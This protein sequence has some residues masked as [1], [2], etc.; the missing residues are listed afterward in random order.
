MANQSYIIPELP[1]NSEDEDVFNFSPYV[2]K[3]DKIL[4][5]NSINSDPL[6][7]GIYGK[8]GEGKTSFL[9]LLATHLSEF[10]D[11]GTSKRI[12]KYHFNPWRY[13]GEDEM[14]LAFFEGLSNMLSIQTNSSLQKAGKFIKKISK[15]FKAIK[16]SSSVGIP[17]FLGTKVTFELNEIL[18]AMGEDLEGKPISPEVLNKVIDDALCESKYKIVIFI[19]DIDRLDK[20]EIYTLFK[21]IKLNANFRNLVYLI[22][23]DPEQVSKAI[24]HRYGTDKLDGKLFIEKIINIPII[25]PR[26][27][28]EDLQLFF[29]KKISDLN[30]LLSLN[31]DNDFKEIAFEFRRFNFNNPRE[32]IRVINSFAISACAIGEEVNLRDLFWIEYLKITNETCYNDI[33][34]YNEET[35]IFTE[36]SGVIDFNDEINTQG[37]PNGFRKH[38]INTYPEIESILNHLFPNNNFQGTGSKI[39]SKT[40]EKE[41]RINSSDHFEKFFSYHTFRKISETNFKIIKNL[42]AEEKEDDL[43]TAI[44][45]LF[46]R[47]AEYKTLYKI[48]NLIEELD[49]DKLLFLSHFLILNINIIPEIGEDMFGRSFRIRIIEKIAIT[50]NDNDISKDYL[51]DLAEEMTLFNLCYFT[52][53]FTVQNVRNELQEVIVRRIKLEKKPFYEEPLNAPNKMIMQIWNNKNSAEF[54]RF[55]KDTLQNDNILLL[56]R[57]FPVYWNNTFFGALT[58]SNYDFMKSIIDVDY[59]YEKLKEYHAELFD[60]HI[61]ISD[62]DFQESTSHTIEENALQFINWHNI[63]KSTSF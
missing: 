43:K 27:E 20:D 2:K 13:S 9:N 61:D 52:R 55:I 3:I 59:I 21:I 14:L 4:Q 16:I 57:N 49:V 62:I 22:A 47:H 8:W 41:L 58:K 33:K 15:Y 24:H 45:N 51:I 26:I 48:E 35:Q 60:K 46:A 28:K 10:K 30:R 17:K 44:V 56:I 18:K 7:I 34:N 11:D 36:M 53:K 29:D 54:D 31:K 39:D 37:K 12:L 1:I 40:L 42:I 19:D 25:L 50:L 23:L 5:A 32:I 38:L 63:E 6:T